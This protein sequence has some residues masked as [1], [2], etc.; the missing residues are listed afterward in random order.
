MLIRFIICLFCLNMLALSSRAQ[1]SGISL[2]PEF[3]FPS[4]N[5]TNIA[6]F[7]YGAGMD[8]D[9]GIS[10]KFSLSGGL[11]WV[12]FVQKKLWGQRGIIPYLPLKAGVR[13]YPDNS[14]YLEGR[15]GYS[16][17]LDNSNQSLALWS[18]GFGSKL[19]L[20]HSSNSIDVGAR[21]ESW[22]GS[23][24]RVDGLSRRSTAFGYIG[25]K[26]VYSFNL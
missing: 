25:L 10:P 7:G 4:G 20:R 26:A 17:S 6:S 8:F 18:L 16:A 5:S 1:H 3:S 9:I 22:L 24:H 12:N 13:Y 14:F 11:S 23:I 15:V 2:G 21:Y 19:K